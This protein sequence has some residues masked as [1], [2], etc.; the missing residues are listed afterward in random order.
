MHGHRFLEAD[1]LVHHGDVLRRHR[2]HGLDAVD[3]IVDALRA[4]NHRERRLV[5]AR[6]VDRDE[7]L[8]QRLLRLTEVRARDVQR[9]LVD[10][11][12]VLDLAQLPRRRL[13]RFR[14]RWRLASSCGIC[15]SDLLR[16]RL[17][18]ADRGV[19]GCRA[20]RDDKPQQRART[21]AGA[22]RFRTLI[23]DS[24]DIACSRRTG[25]AGTSQVQ[26]ASRGFGY[27]QPVTRAKVLHFWRRTSP[28]PRWWWTAQSRRKSRRFTV[29]RSRPRERPRTRSAARLAGASAALVLAGVSAGGGRGPGDSLQKQVSTLQTRARTARCSICMR[30]IHACRP[31]KRVSRR[32]RPNRRASR[33]QAQ[34]AQQLAATQHTLESLAA[35]ARRQPA[36]ALQA[37]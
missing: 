9:N 20:G 35:A 23:T 28:K 11:Q 33:Q 1:H 26:E 13:V 6:R 30:S 15:A 8:H 36:H 34:L 19:A 21:S 27:L 24:R 12:V 32:S 5:V 2:L 3:E 31:R 25:G 17:L 4:E 37:R 16:L 18:R 22:C 10:L 14:A 29:L 7:P